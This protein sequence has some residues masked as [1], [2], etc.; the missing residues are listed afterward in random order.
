MLA[1]KAGSALS[2]P[3]GEVAETARQNARFDAAN[4]A[5]SATSI[6]VRIRRI[7]SDPCTNGPGFIF[8]RTRAGYIDSLIGCRA[9]GW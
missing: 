7:R 6:G 3:E 8:L 1:L 9:C 5:G 4:L 2:N